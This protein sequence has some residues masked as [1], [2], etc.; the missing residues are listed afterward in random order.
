MQDHFIGRSSNQLQ[1]ETG[2]ANSSNLEWNVSC[3][4][5]SKR[6]STNAGAVQNPSEFID[7]EMC[8]YCNIGLPGEF[9]RQPTL[10]SY[11][12]PTCFKG[13]S[14]VLTKPIRAVLE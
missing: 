12:G 3:N 13:N 14:F 7:I 2:P 6:Q 1:Q 5:L 9:S 8:Q 4:L 11:S 10:P